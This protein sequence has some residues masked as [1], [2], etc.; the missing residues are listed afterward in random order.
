MLHSRAA[1]AVRSLDW[2]L[3]PCSSYPTYP[4]YEL[5]CVLL[6]KLWVIA[7]HDAKTVVVTPS[8]FCVTTKS[9]IIFL[10][11]GVFLSNETVI[12]KTDFL[13]LLFSMMCHHRYMEV[14][15]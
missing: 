9:F 12:T 14:L 3:T 13:I 2:L 7:S 11:K 15:F 6:P 1:V 8:L 10:E 5:C 4:C